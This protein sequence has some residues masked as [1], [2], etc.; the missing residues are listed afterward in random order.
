MTSS[1]GVVGE[2]DGIHVI[3]VMGTAGVSVLFAVETDIL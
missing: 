1:V 3:C 2:E